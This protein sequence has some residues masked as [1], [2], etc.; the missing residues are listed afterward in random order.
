MNTKKIA[1][2]ITGAT[3]AAL[4]TV[5]AVAP[6][7]ADDHT[8]SSDTTTTAVR[9]LGD[10]WL[11]NHLV[12]DVSNESPVVVAPSVDTGDIASGNAVASG[13]DT[14]VGSGNTTNV[15]TSVSDLVDGTVGDISS[16]VSDLVDDVM[17][18]VDL[19]DILG[20]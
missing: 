19:S 1:L 17:S 9:A 3:A 14:A 13:N 4:L 8:S 18:D 11:T 10:T 20:E 5:G 7:M 6:A 15:G 2:G 16:D 12:G